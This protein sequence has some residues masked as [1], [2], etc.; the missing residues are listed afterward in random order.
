LKNLIG[1]GYYGKA[2]FP[3][4]DTHTRLSIEGKPFKELQIIHIKSSK[5]NTIIALTESNGAVLFNTSAG[6]N[7][8]KNSKKSSTTAAQ[9]A[10]VT[11]SEYMK[12]RGLNNIRLVLK[13]LGNGRLA[14]I[15]TLQ[16]NGINI[17]S[18]SDVTSVPIP[19]MKPLRPKCQ[20]RV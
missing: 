4:V 7:G 11:M 15:K 3:T 9:A 14:C 13:G 10:A 17:V 8:F 1:A 16:M 2:L 19:F 6:S 20:R 18:I 5:N 12:R